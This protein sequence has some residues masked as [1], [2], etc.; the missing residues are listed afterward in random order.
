MSFMYSVLKELSKSEYLF[1]IGG[2]LLFTLLLLII[3]FEIAHAKKV[4]KY[5][6]KIED[7]KKQGVQPTVEDYSE[8]YVK[9]MEQIRQMNERID[10]I[11]KRRN[12]KEN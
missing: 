4:K 7:D 9:A 11:E 10:N 5:N 1:L 8:F 3:V 12:K 6:K 2:V